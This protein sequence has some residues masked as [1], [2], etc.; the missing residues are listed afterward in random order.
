MKTSRRSVAAQPSQA[1]S[2]GSGGGTSPPRV[3]RL[4]RAHSVI[5]QGNGSPSGQTR[6][7]RTTGGQPGGDPYV[8]AP[9]KVGQMDFK[10]G[11]VTHDMGSTKNKDGRT[12]PLVPELR[13]VLE[14][15]RAMTEALQKKIGRSRSIGATRSS[16][17]S[18]SGRA[19]R[20]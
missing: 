7:N 14:A 3:V 5:A 2:L 19:A 20:N 9:R 10:A 11:V 12:F 4:E 1:R 13:A 18:C 8:L 6:I 16:T 15:Q 17:R